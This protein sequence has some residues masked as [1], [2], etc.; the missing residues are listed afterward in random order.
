VPIIK[1][2]L[3]DPGFG[4]GAL[5]ITPGHDATD[6]KSAKEIIWKPF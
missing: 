3:V 5:K 6:L 4:T 1:D 2:K